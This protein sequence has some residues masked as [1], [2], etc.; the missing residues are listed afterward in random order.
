[1]PLTTCVSRRNNPVRQFLEQ[2]FPHTRPLVREARERV[3]GATTLRPAEP[4]L[5]TV[6]GTAFDC[7]AQYYFANTP[8]HDMARTGAKFFS[9]AALSEPDPLDPQAPHL[10]IWEGFPPGTPEQLAQER[11]AQEFFQELAAVEAAIRPAG[12]CLPPAQEVQLNR[13]CYVLALFE[14]LGRSGLGPARPWH[15]PLYTLPRLD[16]DA[17]LALAPPPAIARNDRCTRDL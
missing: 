5:W 17:L 15:W 1:M 13:Y 4:G 6:V 10:P 16:L 9:S 3:A 7:R 14:A 12:R 2:R 8:E 11:L